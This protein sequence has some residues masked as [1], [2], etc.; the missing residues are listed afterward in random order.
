MTFIKPISSIDESE[1]SIRYS[2]EKSQVNRIRG[3]FAF[4]FY[5]R[6]PVL[7]EKT[8]KNS[9]LYIKGLLEYLKLTQRE[10]FTEWKVLV[11]TD[12]FTYD[13][14]DKFPEF[15]AQKE[16]IIFGIISWPK[17]QRRNERPQVNGLILRTL[18]FRAPFDFKDSIVF[19]RDADTLFATKLGNASNLNSFTDFLYSWESTFLSLIPSIQEELGTPPLILAT[20]RHGDPNTNGTIPLYH[21]NGISNELTNRKTRFGVFGGFLNTVPGISVF[22]DLRVWDEFIQYVNQRSRRLNRRTIKQENAYYEFTNN[23]KPQQITRDTQFL[24][25]FLM[26]NALEN[27]VFFEVKG[28][29][30][31]PSLDMNFSRAVKDIYVEMV[32][33]NFQRRDPVY[34]GGKYKQLRSKIEKRKTR[35]RR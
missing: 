15:W 2:I 17:Y 23:G 24:I 29:D 13:Q 21:S 10:P 14:L 28:E 31:S 33:N 4:S 18:R 26:K 3:L 8:P 12:Q 1:G 32:N 6:D 7:G 22:Q 16:N 9:P 30:V 34:L 20:G 19:I 25:F 5:I 35:K 27:I 11:Y